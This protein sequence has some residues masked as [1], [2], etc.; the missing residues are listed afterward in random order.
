MYSL[1]TEPVT[2]LS[3]VRYGLLPQARPLQGDAVPDDVYLPSLAPGA[4]V[5]ECGC[6]QNVPA[7]TFSVVYKMEAQQFALLCV[8][9]VYR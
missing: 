9:R 7:P 3:L 1:L 2:R 4:G 6:I 5:V 8:A